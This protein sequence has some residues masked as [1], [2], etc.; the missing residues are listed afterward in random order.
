[1]ILNF[2]TVAL[3]NFIRSKILSAIHVLG[4]A[5][6]ISASLV[7]FLVVHFENSF[8]K[9]EEDGDLIYRVVMDVQFN[10][11]DGHGSAVPA[12]LAA[13][14][15]AEVTGIDAVVPVMT[16][17]GDGHA[18]VSFSDRGKEHVFKSQTNIVFTKP[19]YFNMVGFEWLAG[20]PETSMAEPF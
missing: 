9:F 11:I 5:I 20:S 2:F 6:G 13:A 4:L 3:R 10:G 18:K 15:E 17:Q 1:M 8:D 12:P 19:S 7:I 16:F 14:V